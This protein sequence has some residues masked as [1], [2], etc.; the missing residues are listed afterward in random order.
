MTPTIRTAVLAGLLSIFGTNLDAQTESC[1]TGTR[2]VIFFSNGMETSLRR[3]E[4][5]K[6]RLREELDPLLV[7]PIQKDSICYSVAYNSNELGWTDMLE[8]YIQLISSDT[9]RFWRIISRIESL[10]NVLQQGFGQIAQLLDSLTYVDDN[11]LQIQVDRY[12]EEIAVNQ[13]KVIIVPHSQ[14][15]FYANRAYSLLFESASPLP[16]DKFQ[17]VSV[18]TP[19]SLVGGNGSYTTLYGDFILAV[20][21]RLNP[22]TLTDGT[23]CNNN[24]QLPGD[25]AFGCHD[26][27]TSYLKGTFSKSQI[28]SQVISAIPT[29]NP[30]SLRINAFQIIRND[31]LYEFG[32]SASSTGEFLD[33]A[34]T[35]K[36]EVNVNCTDIIFIGC[37]WNFFAVVSAPLNSNSWGS[38]LSDLHFGNFYT[39]CIIVYDKAG[40]SVTAPPGSC[41]IN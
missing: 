16:P 15:N 3:A 20:P 5:N 10:P 8:A 9:A 32:W 36:A 34:D 31:I 41:K 21:G 2:T 25:N 1:P 6:K 14:G 38:A 11:D 22:N 23:D 12:R 28:L 19:D 40:N 4:D 29:D 7:F 39:Y 13:R 27:L 37:N 18:A 26:F 30:P 17:I 24:G 33:R 35:Y